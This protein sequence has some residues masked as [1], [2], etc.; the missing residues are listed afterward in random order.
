MKKA[1]KKKV[2]K[3][4]TKKKKSLCGISYKEYQL[5]KAYR[6]MNKV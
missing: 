2:E 3:T 4:N 6:K 1:A 5:I